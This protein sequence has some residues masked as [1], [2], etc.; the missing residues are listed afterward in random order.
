MI[1]GRVIFDLDGTLIDSVPGIVTAL[2]RAFAVV[3]P[4]HPLPP[5]APHVGPPVAQM[6][7]AI[8]PDLSGTTHAAVLAAFRA[9]YDRDG[10]RDVVLLPGAWET[11][12]ALATARI[13]CDVATY[14]P[15]APTQR[16][17]DTLGLTPLIA[18]VR[19]GDGPGGAAVDK[20]AMLTELVVAAGVAPGSV[21]YV[22]D[23]PLDRVAAGA[24][25]TRFVAVGPDAG[26]LTVERVLG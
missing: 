22:G 11:L 26:P 3:V 21:V 8:A 17:L 4:D 9:G 10:W 13:P 18:R 5:L 23:T 25:G 20:A 14:K 6:I 16:I 2:T 12:R 1:V 15:L 24:A 7:S 19:G